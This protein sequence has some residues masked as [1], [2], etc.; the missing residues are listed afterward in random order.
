[1]A[2]VGTS[3]FAGISLPRGEPVIVLGVVLLP[4]RLRAGKASGDDNLAV[5]GESQ[6]HHTPAMG[7]PA[8]Y[9]RAVFNLPKEDLRLGVRSRGNEFAIRGN[10]Q[11]GY[12]AWM[13]DDLF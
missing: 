3:Q 12:R 1:M 8:A 7:L 5:R 6:A 13:I 9:F 4:R 2:R 11:G 10:R